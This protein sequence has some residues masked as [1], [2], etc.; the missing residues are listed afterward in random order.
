MFLLSWLTVRCESPALKRQFHQ[1][2]IGMRPVL[3]DVDST[4]FFELE[5]S[6]LESKEQLGDN[7]KC[8]VRNVQCQPGYDPLLMALL[9]VLKIFHPSQP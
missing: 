3:D 9:T 2:S 6:R 5:I 7:W 4:A 8:M 1:K